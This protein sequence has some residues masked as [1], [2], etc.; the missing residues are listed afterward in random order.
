M[1]V[2]LLQ[3]YTIVLQCCISDLESYLIR[4]DNIIVLK[5]YQVRDL[6]LIIIIISRFILSIIIFSTISLHL[7][8]YMLYHI[9][10][11]HLSYSPPY[12]FISSS[13][14]WE[15]LHLFLFHS[16]TWVQCIIKCYN[17]FAC[18]KNLVRW[19]VGINFKPHSTTRQATVHAWWRDCAWWNYRMGNWIAQFER[20]YSWR[21]AWSNMSYNVN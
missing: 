2:I 14:R 18:D 8:Y 20:L 21:P 13:W 16:L 9:A 11:S 4:Y 7:I 10:S 5:I 1:C 17:T 3:A 6:H 15:D 19:T 12:R